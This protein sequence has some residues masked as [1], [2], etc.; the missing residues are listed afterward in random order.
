ML[1]A[2]CDDAPDAAGEIVV[3]LRLVARIALLAAALSTGLAPIEARAQTPSPS[4]APV[5]VPPKQLSAPEVLYPEGASGSAVVVLELTVEVDGSVGAVTVEAGDEPFGSAARDNAKLWRFEPATRDGAPMRAAIR[6]KVTFTP[7][8]STSVPPPVV[9]PKTTAA[10][11]T[12][13]QGAPAPAPPI[14]IFVEAERPEIGTTSTGGGEIRILPGAFGDPF[15]AIEALPGVTPIISGLPYFYVRGA[16]PGNTGYF[17]DDVRVPMLFHL[18]AGPAIIAPAL[19]DRVD[20][21]PGGYPAEYGR[22]TGGIVAGVTNEPSARPR[23]EWNVRLF[24]A[25]AMVE[26][27]IGKD[28]SGDALVAGRYGYPGLLLS[29]LSPEVSLQYWDY[30]LRAGKRLSDRDRISIFVFGAYDRLYDKKAEKTLFNTQF[31]RADLRWDRL[32]PQGR[33]RTALTLGFDQ[34]ALGDDTASDEDVRIRTFG[35]R[36]RTELEQ[37]LDDEVKLR[38]GA[39]VGLDR[40]VLVAGP[41]AQDVRRD[42]PSRSDVAGGVRADLVVRASKRVEIVPGVRLDG[43]SSRSTTLFAIDPRL[44]TRVGLAAGVT[45]LSSF[46]VTHQP[47]AFI[48]PIPG[49]QPDLSG[50]LQQSFQM[51]QGVELALPQKITATLTGFR[52]TLLN[53]T[54]FLTTCID[55]NGRTSGGSSDS[56]GGRDFCDINDRTRGTTYGAEVL[57]KRALT[58]RLG[59]WIAYT[60]SRSDRTYRGVTRLSQ[61]DRPHVLAVVGSLDLGAHWRFGTRFTFVSGRPVTVVPPNGFGLPE[62]VIRLPSF[63][64]IDWRLE[65]RWNTSETSWVSLVFEWFNTT[66]RKEPTDLS[67]RYGTAAR[68]GYE[69]ASCSVEEIG[70]ITIPSVGVEGGF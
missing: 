7:P 23:G 33:L 12:G 40:F 31:H 9:A 46:A 37:R 24:D 11:P 53:L 27:P 28:G 34:S 61:F 52:H 30:Q 43:F 57:I 8:G 3:T 42:Y 65:K 48:V 58:E 35:V 18:G 20:F 49:L 19:I 38:A 50:G 62:Q 56:G 64:R 15:R 17:I 41:N 25:S 45:W 14:D 22:Y 21:F 44:A 47:P 68:G 39:D 1:G 16:P 6:A 55:V 63:Y 4:S 60:L 32:L 36:L 29:L 54:D 10:P 13:K 66:L 67:C 70:P 2:T 26:S 59:G 69:L 5:L 51:S